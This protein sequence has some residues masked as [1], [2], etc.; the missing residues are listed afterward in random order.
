MHTAQA[1][2]RS[3]ALRMPRGSAL[4]G[5]V[6]QPL[7]EGPY[8]LVR[9]DASDWRAKED[10]S[11]WAG[12]PPRDDR[13]DQSR[14]GR[15]PPFGG[16]LDVEAPH[17]PCLPLLLHGRAKRQ[18]E[19]IPARLRLG[20]EGQCGIRGR[21]SERGGAGDHREP[22]TVGDAS[23]PHGT[24]Q[25]EGRLWRT[26]MNAGHRGLRVAKGR[27]IG[28]FSFQSRRGRNQDFPFDLGFWRASA[29]QE[30]HRN[31]IFHRSAGIS[32]AMLAVWEMHAMHIDVCAVCVAH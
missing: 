31:P 17:P 3:G 26:N 6:A 10:N 15:I 25:A 19:G 9:H 29:G 16:V 22:E 21:V 24:R 5:F 23:G 13:D 12:W 27:Q 30:K 1:G 11:G 7:N 32:L 20:V 18:H 2:A 4:L 28:A 8:P 14:L